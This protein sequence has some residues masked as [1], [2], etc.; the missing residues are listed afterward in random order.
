MKWRCAINPIDISLICKSLGDST[1]LQI[2][3]LLSEGEKCACNI[4]EA[5]HITQPTLSYHMKNL[6]ES[7]LVNVRKEGKWSYYS[8]N[9]ET[10]KDFKA[11]FGELTCTYNR[12]N[13]TC[14]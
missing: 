1:R 4:L 7:A 9:C 13:C 12:G 2:L 6:A 8:I 3:Q 5:F 10:L 11:F 14:D